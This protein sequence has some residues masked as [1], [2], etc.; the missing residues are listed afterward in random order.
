MG[1]MGSEALVSG[2]QKESKKKARRGAVQRILE[3]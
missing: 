1:I 2:T 3:V